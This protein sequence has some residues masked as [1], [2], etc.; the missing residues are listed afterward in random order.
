M[1]FTKS[2]DTKLGQLQL[3]QALSNALRQ[4]QVLWLVAGGSNIP[5]VINCLKHIKSNLTKNLQLLLTDERYGPKGHQASNYQQYV[6]NG[7][8]LKQ[9]TFLDIL[10]L[11]PTPEQALERYQKL[12]K[13]YIQQCQI[14]IGQFGIGEDGHIAGVLP[15]S[16]GISSTE[17]IIF[18]RSEPYDR[19]TLTLGAIKTVD[20]SFVFC[21]GPNKLDALRRLKLAQEPLESLPALILNQMDNVT[22]YN[23]Q[24]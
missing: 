11:N 4:N 21:F 20:V 8:V 3:A 15:Y 24:V 19:L 10:D 2:A 5:I 23:D 9:A 7:L 12:Y 1:R 17:K 18:Y 14:V 22:V 6:S 16:P 13:K